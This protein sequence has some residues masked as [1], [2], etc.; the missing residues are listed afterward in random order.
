MYK[1]AKR[2]YDGLQMVFEEDEMKNIL[3][4]VIGLILLP[5]TDSRRKKFDYLENTFTLLK[6]F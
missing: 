6:H 2:D 5:V 4:F 3:H 1:N